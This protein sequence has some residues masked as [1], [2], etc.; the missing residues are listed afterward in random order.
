MKQRYDR[1]IEVKA[2]GHRIQVNR[3]SSYYIVKVGTENM[4]NYDKKAK[5]TRYDELVSLKKYLESICSL[6]GI[7]WA[8]VENQLDKT[9]KSL[10]RGDVSIVGEPGVEK[11]ERVYSVESWDLNKISDYRNLLYIIFVI[12]LTIILLFNI[13]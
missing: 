12:L 4:N 11:G 5:S 3:N 13:I 1:I 6:K 7:D 2:N 9:L 8:Q 10:S